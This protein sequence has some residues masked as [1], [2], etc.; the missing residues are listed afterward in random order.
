MKTF[1]SLKWLFLPLLMTNLL[2]AI[3]NPSAQYC[4]AMGYTYT[5][6]KGLTGIRE[7]KCLFPDHSSANAWDFYRGKVKKSFSYCEKNG[8]T[9]VTQT[10]QSKGYTQEIPMC[11]PKGKQG[12][13]QPVPM[14]D[15][16]EKEGLLPTLKERSAVHL[17]LGRIP[18]VSTAKTATKDALPAN[19][20]WRDH[21][22]HS[23]IGPVKN[24]GSCGAC[25]A[26]AATASA[27]GVYNVANK[28]FDAKTIDLSEDFIA[29]CLGK[30]GPYS[31][32]F[33]GC[34]GADYSYS[35]L[36]ALTKEG[37]TDEQHYPTINR[38]PGSCTHR[39]DPVVKFHSWG[40]LASNDDEAIKAAI[41]T[42]GVID[43]AVY[44][45]RDFQNYNGGVFEDT[46]TDCPSGAYTTT[47]H[48]VSLV[49][50]GTDN[51]GLYWILRNSWDTGW[52]ES[53]YMR[54]RA[55]S[56]RV[57]CAATYLTYTSDNTSAPVIA[58]IVN[59]LF[60]D[61]DNST[62]ACVVGNW[63]VDYDW[64]CDNSSSVV[65]FTL[66][67]DST[68]TTGDGYHGTWDLNGK[69]IVMT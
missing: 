16:M 20:D 52:G 48:A 55:H 41:Q 21:N 50:W 69:D 1:T 60:S 67:R 61:S 62:P 33:S 6:E 12:V 47:N 17:P 29:W 45:T 23:Y 40:R 46:Q 35:E 53:G 54:I 3:S 68:F 10:D 26:Y 37:I 42:Y 63:D 4:K 51:Q 9:M 27:E 58:P 19:F 11:I 30:Y 65:L 59:Y 56:A 24:Q 25:Y 5:M 38:D 32:H 64:D 43:V 34:D 22:G 15:L 14:L 31:N 18:A 66:N 57:A 39:N 28:K 2:L 44:V 49:G 13:S 7:G 36:T 8:Y